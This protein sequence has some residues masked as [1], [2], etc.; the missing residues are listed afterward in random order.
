MQKI[1]RHNPLRFIT[2]GT[3]TLFVSVII[4]I[5]AFVAS[6]WI[7]SGLKSKDVYYGGK[8]PTIVVTGSMDPVIPVNAIVMVENVPFEELEVGDI[9]TYAS[10]LGYSVI[11]RIVD[12]RWTINIDSDGGHYYLRT[13][14]DANASM[15]NVRVT[16]DMYNGKVTTIYT[17]AV[18]FMSF[19]FGK[20]DM[21][22]VGKSILRILIGFVILALLVTAVLLILYY[23]FELITINLFWL[24]KSDKMQESIDWLDDHTNKEQ[25]NAIIDRYKAAVKEAKWWKK[26]LLYFIFRKYYDVMCS[27]ESKARKTV[28]WR[29]ILN[30]QISK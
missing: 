8:R 17:E 18:P 4:I 9:I 12:K 19:V 27:E 22:N 11:H 5:I 15:D 26:I 1:Y 30:K 13:K 2:Y 20:F 25:F 21:D 14:G 23:I 10:P 29:N 16:E 28:R 3:V 7:D 24:K 6:N